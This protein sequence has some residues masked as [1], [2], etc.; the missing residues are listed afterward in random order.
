MQNQV[1]R[2]VTLGILLV[3]AGCNKTG[4]STDATNSGTASS[5]PSAAAAPAP[6]PAPPVVVPAGTSLTVT[7]DQTVG[8]KQNQSGD[9]FEASLAEPVTVDGSQVLPSGAKIRG[10]V[11]EAESAGHLKGAAEL[12]LTLDSITVRGERYSIATSTYVEKGKARGKRT[13]VGAGGGAA[14]GAIIGALAGGGKGA[15]I[16]AGAGAGAGTAGAAYTGDRDVSVSAETR[17]H[18]KLTK[19]LSVAQ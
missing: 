16:G 3:A 4:T 10:T 5:A 1:V 17:L 18:F 12:S 8:T 19:S 6:A 9:H 15:A 11:T 13:A 7:V 2:W 14:V